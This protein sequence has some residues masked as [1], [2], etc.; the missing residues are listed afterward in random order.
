[1]R[2]PSKLT[3]N[4]HEHDTGLKAKI[5]LCRG[6]SPQHWV[7]RFNRKNSKY[8]RVVTAT[9]VIALIGRLI[10]TLLFRPEKYQEYLDNQIKQATEKL[11]A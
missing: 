4:L 3:I 11:A 8:H 2:L 5:E 6:H 10:H 9:I 1:M 7:C